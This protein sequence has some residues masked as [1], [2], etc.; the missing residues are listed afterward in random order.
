MLHTKE[1]ALDNPVEGWVT[2][3][4]ASEIVNR[5]ISTIR[6]WV[7]KDKIRCYRVGTSAIKIVNVAEVVAYSEQ[8]TRLVFSTRGKKKKRN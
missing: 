7:S 3:N 2:L 5:D 1:K 4:E 8:A 6:Y